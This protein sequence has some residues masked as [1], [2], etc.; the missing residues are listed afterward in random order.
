MKASISAS[1]IL[2]VVLTGTVPFRIQKRTD[3]GNAFEIPDVPSVTYL[4]ITRK[5]EGCTLVFDLCWREG[6]GIGRWVKPIEVLL[7]R[8]TWYDGE[9]E[10][11]CKPT[12]TN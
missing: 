12:A 5:D 1:G 3:C 6:P 9:I 2:K 8:P 10:D 11:R 7:L 4:E